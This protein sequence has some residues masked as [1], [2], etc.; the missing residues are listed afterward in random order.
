MS[1]WLTEVG[2]YASGVVPLLMMLAGFGM[3]VG[4]LV[5]GRICDRWRHAGTAALGQ[6][7]SGIG[8][9]FVFFVPGSPV[10][11]AILTFWI[12]FGL[13]FVSSPQQ[14]LM[15]EAGKGG[16]ELLGGATVQVAFNF[17]NAVGSIIGGAMLTVSGMNYHY[18]ALGGLPLA[19]IAVALLVLFSRRYEGSAASVQQSR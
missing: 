14:L 17:G 2:G 3:V 7:V 19:V 5:G 10:I 18:P 13:F 12:A 15:A 11:C 1:P 4:G 16:G 9:L 6:A 8:L